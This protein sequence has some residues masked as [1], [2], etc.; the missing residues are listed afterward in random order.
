M[1]LDGSNSQT[2]P[3]L[4]SEKPTKPPKSVLRHLWLLQDLFSLAITWEGLFVRH[5]DGN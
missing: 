1:N 4:L 5:L 3:N 2:K